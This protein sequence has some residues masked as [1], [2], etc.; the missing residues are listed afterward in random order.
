MTHDLPVKPHTTMPGSLIA[1]S[2]AVDANETSARLCLV[3][4]QTSINYSAE[5]YFVIVTSKLQRPCV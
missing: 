4:E 2:G 3:A 5:L 1:K